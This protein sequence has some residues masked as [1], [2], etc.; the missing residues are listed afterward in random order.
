MWEYTTVMTGLLDLIEH[1]VKI[2]FPPNHRVSET[3]LIEG[4]S[5]RF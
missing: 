5:L 1:I 4:Y 3:H 2:H